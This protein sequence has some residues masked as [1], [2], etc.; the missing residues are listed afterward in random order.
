MPLVRVE[1]EKNS[2]PGAEE[3]STDSPKSSFDE[4]V[5]DVSVKVA[6]IVKS[7]AYL[8]L[9]LIVLLIFGGGYFYL[10]VTYA[11]F[12]KIPILNGPVGVY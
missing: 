3:K 10:I 6:G 5:D 9:L 8:L 7:P 12:S 2:G 1:A 11:D 4:A